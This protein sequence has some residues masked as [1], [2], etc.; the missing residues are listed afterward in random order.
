M[1]CSGDVITVAEVGADPL[2]TLLSAR[3]LQLVVVDEADEIP[4]TYWG[5]PEAGL[6]GHRLYVQLDTPV[7]SALHEAAHFLCMDGERR[8]TLDKDAG[9]DFVEENAV[10]YLQIVIADEIP[11][12]SRARMMADMD[13]WGYTFRL[14]S[15][16]RWF[17]E[18]AG[19]AR[20]WLL[21]RGLIS[22]SDRYQAPVTAAA[23]VE[24]V[25]PG[26]DPRASSASDNGPSV[27]F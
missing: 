11:W 27:P 26:T 2:R 3:G 9:G 21:S 6:I 14:G 17:E 8:K 13:A 5:A 25:S 23:P 19:D 10:C 24:S 4:G 12:M 16:R 15:A 18:D 7:H 22:T 20:E 1:P